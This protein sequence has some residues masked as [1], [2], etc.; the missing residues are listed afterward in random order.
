[1]NINRHISIYKYN[2]PE[3]VMSPY[4]FSGINYR[5]KGVSP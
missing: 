3:P 5:M 1:M 2:R 4:Q